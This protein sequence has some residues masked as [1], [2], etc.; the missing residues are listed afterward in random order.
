MGNYRYMWIDLIEDIDKN[1]III[2]VSCDQKYNIENMTRYEIT[3]RIKHIFKNWS[4]NVQKQNDN[5]LN[6][7]KFQI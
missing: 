3:E 4:Y 2:S 5:L 6:C 1:K 7:P